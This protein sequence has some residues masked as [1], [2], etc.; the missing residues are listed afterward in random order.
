METASQ[1]TM[2][3][4]NTSGSCD[5]EECH[6]PWK[7]VSLVR[8]DGKTLDL[9]IENE[10]QMMCFIHVFYKLIC[11]PPA[12][13]KFL[14]EFKMMKFRMKLAYMARKQEVLIT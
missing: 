10:S 2:M 7:C 12:G 9:T 3:S 4:Q 13:N 6:Y 14:R 11:K 1:G 5:K 8:A